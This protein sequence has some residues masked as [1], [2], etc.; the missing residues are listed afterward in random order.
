MQQYKSQWDLRP[1]GAE[2]TSRIHQAVTQGLVCSEGTPDS[3]AFGDPAGAEDQ[4]DFNGPAGVEVQQYSKQSDLRPAHAEDD[5][6]S[7]ATTNPT[8]AGAADMMF[9]TKRRGPPHGAVGGIWEWFIGFGRPA[10]AV[11]GIR[12]N[13]SHAGA[14]ETYDIGMIGSPT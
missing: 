8:S 14:S 10:R 2:E 5:M 4:Y 3:Q 7:D 1:A 11:E 6:T 13:L 12:W 9:A